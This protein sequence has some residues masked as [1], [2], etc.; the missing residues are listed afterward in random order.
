MRQ[1]LC[2]VK[3]IDK[4]HG[5]A[6]DGGTANNEAFGLACGTGSLDSLPKGGADNATGGLEI[7]VTGQHVVY[8]VRERASDVLVILAAKDDGMPRRDGLEALEVLR[9]V[10]RQ[11][12][13][14]PDD[15]V[16][17]NSYN[18]G[19]KHNGLWGRPLQRALGY[20]VM[21]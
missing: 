8:A 20:G 13:V 5:F 10:P 7:L 14:A 11:V 9:K 1:D 16:F 21:G 4:R 18:C 3:F 12:P 19:N 2:Q 6:I 17:R 15:I